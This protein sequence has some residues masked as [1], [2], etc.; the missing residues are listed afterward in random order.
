MVELEAVEGIWGIF[1]CR[2]GGPV[3]WDIHKRRVPSAVHNLSAFENSPPSPVLDIL[4]QLHS[5]G[6][7]TC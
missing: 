2:D 4:F 3:F 6:R 7:K 1:K 5:F